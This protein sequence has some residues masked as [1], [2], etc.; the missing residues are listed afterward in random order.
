VA[1][2]EIKYVAEVSVELGDIPLVECVAGEINQVLLNLVINAAQ[3]IQGQQRNEMG[4]IFIGTRLEADRVHCVIQDDGPGIP[5]GIQH[6][7][8]DPF[9]TTKDVG[10]GTGLG[11]NIAYDI[12][13]NKHRGEIHLDSAVGRGTTFD[14]VLPVTFQLEREDK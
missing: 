4:H 5:A 8:Y 2:N 9:Y 7:I 11:L 6:R 10:K 3:A 14:I 13:V 1:H 12:I